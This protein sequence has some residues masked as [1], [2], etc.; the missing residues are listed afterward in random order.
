[1]AD[2]AGGGDLP[3]ATASLFDPST[4]AAPWAQLDTHLGARRRSPMSRGMGRV[5]PWTLPVVVSL[6]GA[7]APPAG[8][9]SL[10][11]ATALLVYL[12]SNTLIF[13][14]RPIHPPPLPPQAAWLA[15]SSLPGALPPRCMCASWA[16]RGRPPTRA[17]T[18]GYTRCGACWAAGRGGSEPRR[19]PQAVD[20]RSRRT[21]SSRR[22][23]PTAAV[24]AAARASRAVAAEVRVAST[25]KE[26]QQMAGLQTEGE[27]GPRARVWLVPPFW[28]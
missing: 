28:W 1:M 3:S 17:P 27:I 22:R 25:N 8:I 26:Q 11:E 12:S 2:L 14:H 18:W 6:R 9:S 4:A 5:Q 15:P 7:A 13:L 16:R 21:R 23:R 20:P 24:V 10:A 19:P